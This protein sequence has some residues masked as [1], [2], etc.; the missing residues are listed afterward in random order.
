LH[1]AAER[2]STGGVGGAAGDLLRA[3]WRRRPGMA[4]AFALAVGAVAFAVY[5]ATAIR[6]VSFGDWAE[7]QVVP[8][9]LGI[10]HPTGY[11]TYTLLGALVSA[12]PAGSPA[13][14]ANLLSGACTAAALATLTLMLARLGVRPVVG[15]LVALALGFTA[16]IWLNSIHAEVHTLHLLFVAL[17]LHRLLVWAQE[18]RPR[19]LWLGGLLLGLSFGNHMLTLT[20]APE[21]VL[22]ALWLGR[23]TILAQP[24]ILLPAVF[25]F[26]VGLSVYLYLPLR[27]L[28]KPAVMYADLSNLSALITHVTGS[29]FGGQSTGLTADGPVRFYQQLQVW[30]EAPGG[31]ILILAIGLAVFGLAVLW[32]TNRAYAVVLLAVL[33]IHAYIDN[34]EDP[35]RR[36]QYLFTSSAVMILYLGVAAEAFVARVERAWRGWHAFEVARGVAIGLIALA[37]LLLF[38]N[39]VPTANQSVN[40]QG[41]QFVDTVLA[42]LPPDAVLFDLWDVRTPLEYAQQIEGKGR[43]VTLTEN[44]NKALAFAAAGRPVYVLQVFD[45]GVEAMRAH[46]ELTVVAD[47]YVPYGGISAPYLRPLYRV[48]V[49]STALVRPAIAR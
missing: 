11:P 22:G 45:A 10:M 35:G 38:V 44:A 12:I 25:E 48:D 1:P 37:P 13:F 4:G 23:R 42:D 39:T 41:Q 17:L 33:L 27:S 49:P 14:K 15:A 32:R 30:L 3:A 31:Y 40:D 36:D 7:A 24:R 34:N 47:I 16:N 28:D 46:Y 9:T 20:L 18:Q 2:L 8:A 29:Q 19:D 21:I 43:G 5:A 26:L 6:G